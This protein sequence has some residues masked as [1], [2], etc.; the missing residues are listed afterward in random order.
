M[1]VPLCWPRPPTNPIYVLILESLCE[2]LGGPITSSEIYASRQTQFNNLGV[3]DLES[4]E[5]QLKQGVRTSLWLV[6]AS[7]GSPIKYRFNPDAATM[8]TSNRAYSNIDAYETG[9]VIQLNSRTCPFSR[10]TV[11]PSSGRVPQVST[12]MIL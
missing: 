9:Q 2:T 5:I 4:L 8:N 10:G 7:N 11:I 12:F 3:L 6:D 1:S